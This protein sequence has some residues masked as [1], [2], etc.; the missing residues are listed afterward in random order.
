MSLFVDIE[1]DYG[2]FRLAAQF[3]TDGGFTG[4]LGAS[5]CGK[6]QTLRCIAGLQRPD[7]GRIVLDGEVLFDS[8]RRID[9]PP[10]RRNVG[11]L[12]QSG[13]LFPHMT[14]RENLLAALH[15]ERDKTRRERALAEAAALLG[16][17]GLES[18]RPAQL[19]GGQA[20]RVA[21]GRILLNRP[22]ALLLDEPFSAVDSHLREQLQV[23]LLGWLR[24]FAGDVLLVTHSRDEA[25]HMC[26]R[27]ALM[28]AGRILRA[29]PTKEVFASP[30]SRQGAR[31]TGCKNVAQ[32]RK[33]GPYAVYVPGWDVTLQTAAPVADGLVAIGV[34][35]HA[36]SPA[37][38][39]NRLPVRF[40]GQMEE[41][42]EWIVQ[43]RTPRQSPSAPAIWWRMAKGQKPDAM[44]EALG[45][46]PEDVLLFYS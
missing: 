32:A 35:A 43:V 25:Y 11:Y 13:A 39:C 26:G 27:I 28:D 45:V 36:F 18:R 7:K 19:S 31:L 5:G 42:F 37:Q 15:R 3:E 38:P 9:L 34:R 2:A 46:A 30:G 22:R 16:L 8:A 10:Q 23:D 41:P 40:A 24:G 14:V 21:L 29:G 12:F 44:P 17:Q 4:L 6:S 33:A 1:K 20:Q